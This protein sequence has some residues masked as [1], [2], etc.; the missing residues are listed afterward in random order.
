MMSQRRQETKN[1]L[2]GKADIAS[3]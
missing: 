2:R 3:I 1:R